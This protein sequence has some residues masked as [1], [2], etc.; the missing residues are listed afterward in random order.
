MRLLAPLFVLALL[1]PGVLAQDEARVRTASILVYHPSPDPRAGHPD[2][3][4][5]GSPPAPPPA[6]LGPGDTLFDGVASASAAPEGAPESALAHFRELQRLFL[7]RERTGAPVAIDL[8]GRIDGDRLRFDAIVTPTTAAT[9]GAL[10]IS[11]VVFENGVGAPTADGTRAHPYVARTTVAGAALDLAN[12]SATVERDVA[13][14]AGWRAERLG[15]V[16]IVRA[17]DGEAVQSAAW[18]ARSDA[19]AVQVSKAVLVERATATWCA[20]CGPSDEAL[21]LFASQYGVDSLPASGGSGY[22]RAP[23]PLMLLGLAAGL[24][25]GAVL[26][27]RRPA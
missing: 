3:D 4:P 24:G 26:L 22:L 1:A 11:F 27:R 17:E 21:A 18:L 19:R 12:G 23:T 8:G 20:P 2:A 16:A 10:S 5:L 7:Q 14:D 25:A 9:R 6:G 13:L 15:V